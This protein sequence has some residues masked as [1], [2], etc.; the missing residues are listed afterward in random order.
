MNEHEDNLWFTEIYLELCV[1]PTI[2]KSKDTQG[3]Y[4]YSINGGISE[5]CCMR[6][7]ELHL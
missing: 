2:E 5:F 7:F 1:H 4:I 6:D 3:K